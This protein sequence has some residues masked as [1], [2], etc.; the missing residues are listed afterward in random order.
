MAAQVQ[1]TITAKQLGTTYVVPYSHALHLQFYGTGHPVIYQVPY[2]EVRVGGGGTYS[3]VR[4]GL[5]N[6]GKL[7]PA[8]TRHCDAG[9]A[10][11]RVC[12]PTWVPGYSPHSFEGASRPG[13]WR[14]L[15]GRGFLIHEGA[16]TSQGQVGGSL[17]C[18]EILDGD[19][20]TF[21]AEIEK[22]GGASCPQIGATGGLTVTIE[23]APF[24]VATLVA[25]P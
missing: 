5:Q 14:L 25:T 7:P 15:P 3:A 13:A 6:N 1:V 4:F 10:A 21:L 8:A 16:D 12:A 23:A 18:V 22:L 11:A 9:L 19:W 17:G 2:Y 24:P 20:N